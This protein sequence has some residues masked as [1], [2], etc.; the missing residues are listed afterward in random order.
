MQGFRYITVDNL[1]KSRYNLSM[2]YNY[3]THTKRCKHAEGKDRKYVEQAIKAGLKTLGFS[4]HAPYLFPNTDYYSTYRMEVDELHEYARSIRALKKEYAKDIEI[5]CGFEL[6][7][8]PEFH[9]REMEFLNQVNPDYLIMGQ[10]FIGNELSLL[11]APRQS[12][13]KMLEAYVSQVLEGLATG[14]FLYLAHPDLP[15]FRFSKEA[16]EREYTRLC[17]GAKKLNIPLEINLLGVRENRPY[18]NRKFFEIAAKVGNDVV[19]G[20]DAHDPSHLRDSYPERLAENMI[21]DLG[22]NLI[23]E[24]LL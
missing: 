15:G 21:N 17:E 10:H 8:Y 5:L 23:E 7:Y 22:L 13:D 14:H 19:L 3:H 11:Y 24:K 4:D 2:L 1:K 12:E 9:A 16:V 6:E 18:P 20:I